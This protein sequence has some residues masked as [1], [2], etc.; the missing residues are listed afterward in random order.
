MGGLLW[1]TSVETYDL[2]YAVRG[3]GECTQDCGYPLW[4]VGGGRGGGMEAT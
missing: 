1:L 4:G 2:G 3:I